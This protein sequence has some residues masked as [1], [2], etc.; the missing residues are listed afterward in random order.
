MHDSIP[1]AASLRVAAAQFASVPQLDSNL[2]QVAELTASARERGAD[3]V[4]FPEAST[5]SWQ[6]NAEDTAA[7]ARQDGA[8]A[9]EALSAVAAENSVTLIA[10]TFVSINSRVRNRMVVFSPD[11]S[12][13]GHYDKIH[14]YDSFGYRESDKVEAA[15][16]DQ[17]AG[18]LSVIALG[19][20][21][22]GLFNC[23]DLR[24][25]E[26]TRALV[27]LGADTLLISSAWVEGEHKAE[28]W[29][30]LLKARAIENTSYVIA[31]SQPEP[32]SVGMSMIV[33]PLG[34]ILDECTETTGLAIADLHVERIHEVRRLVPSLQHRKY[35]VVP[36][37]P[38]ARA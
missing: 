17:D 2:Q 30:T 13:I 9:I 6:A 22:V 19:D 21:N 3:L 5:F 15:M 20:L 16:P 18:E 36:G 1:A 8:R 23:Y 31:A 38:G 26:M 11:G 34:D 37:V 14:L 28:H 4:A 32:A 12:Q 24:F 33:D 10:G 35:R 7:F 29:R 25:P 27:D